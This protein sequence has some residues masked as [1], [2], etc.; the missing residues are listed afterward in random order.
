MS[1]DWNRTAAA[2]WRRRR[3]ELRA[4][5]RLDTAQLSDLLGIDRQRDAL[6]QNTQ[7]FL[8][9]RPANNALLWGA[10]GTGKSSLVKAILN[11]F[12][13]TGLRLVEID[14]DDLMDLPEIV[15][16]IA[17]Q[18]YR[19]LL[20]CDDLSFEPGERHYR[21][22]KS[23]L[24]GSV[25]LPPDNVLLYATSNRRHLLPESMRDNQESRVIDDMLHPSDHI[26]ETLSLSDRFG[27][28]LSFYPIG[29]DDYLRMV[30]AHFPDWHGDRAE[31]HAA[32]KRFALA[33]GTRSGRVAR[34]FYNEFTSEPEP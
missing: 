17:E 34:Q 25:E 27:L 23:V 15:D 12:R 21:A 3:G 8:A 4:V 10:R 30:D 22:L 31:L 14:R 24:E 7:R 2:V 9:R 18:R 11:H 28:R 32:A 13:D 16:E 5:R 6:I 19:F 26:E 29:Q 20:F 33:R 1:I